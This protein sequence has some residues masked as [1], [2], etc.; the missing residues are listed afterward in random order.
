MSERLKKIIPLVAVGAAIYFLSRGVPTAAAPAP[1]PTPTPPTVRV[2]GSY[3]IT[4]EPIDDI[5]LRY[6]GAWLDQ[7]HGP[8]FWQKNQANLGVIAAVFNKKV[9]SIPTGPG[10]HTLYVRVSTPDFQWKVCVQV[11]STNLGCKVTSAGLATFSFT[12]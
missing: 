11:D 2:S 4:L 5:Y 8:D 6:A 3:T 1:T 9:I 12:A 10:S 7:D